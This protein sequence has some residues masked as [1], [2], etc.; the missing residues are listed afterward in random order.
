MSKFQPGDII[1]VESQQDPGTY[2]VGVIE[3]TT[4]NIV[5]GFIPEEWYEVRW[6]NS[7]LS[8]KYR[9]LDVDHLWEKSP[10]ANA[11]QEAA[12]HAL[13]QIHS[14]RGSPWID[15]SLDLPEPETK[16]QCQ[17]NWKTYD[18]GFSYYEYCEHC[19]IKKAQ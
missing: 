17:H 19:D 10:I 9:A 5:Q 3:N 15:T 7:G 1:R 13:Q 4:T 11:I 18:S 8:N 6:I 2:N 12:K 14:M 16:K